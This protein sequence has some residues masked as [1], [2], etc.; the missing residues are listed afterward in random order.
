MPI[1]MWNSCTSVV[2]IICAW[3]Q[4][5]WN[6]TEEESNQERVILG[7]STVVTKTRSPDVLYFFFHES[8]PRSSG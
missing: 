7:I 2:P 1:E 3:E 5:D 6:K 4:K 8:T